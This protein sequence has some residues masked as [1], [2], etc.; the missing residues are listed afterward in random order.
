MRESDQLYKQE[1]SI[2]SPVHFDRRIVYELINKTIADKLTNQ[3]FIVLEGLINS[4]VLAADDDKMQVREMD[5]FFAL[6]HFIGSVSGVV[7]LQSVED[8]IDE[9]PSAIVYH[10]F[11]KP[12]VAATDKAK[13]PANEEEQA[14][15]G[16]E[17]GPEE[18][19]GEADA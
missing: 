5:E 18:G 15:E 4:Q 1:E 10:E 2:Y 7:S 9:D 6:E 12:E 19:G 3:K 8:K 16:G 11:P 17:G 14:E 13:K